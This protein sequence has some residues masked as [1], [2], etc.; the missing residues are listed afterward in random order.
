VSNMSEIKN[1]INWDGEIQEAFKSLMSPDW[2]RER[3][4]SYIKEVKDRVLGGCH[5]D[6]DELLLVLT[7]GRLEMGDAER[8][9]KILEIRQR[10]EERYQFSLSFIRKVRMLKVNE[11]QEKRDIHVLRNVYENLKNR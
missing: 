3:D 11:D 2:I 8:V 4:R 6:L 7:P 10:M 9:A 1:I 5:S